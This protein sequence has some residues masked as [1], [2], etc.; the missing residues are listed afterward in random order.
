MVTNIFY[1]QSGAIWKDDFVMFT[2]TLPIPLLGAMELTAWD[3]EG[4]QKAPNIFLLLTDQMVF[5]L[6]I[7]I[8]CALAS[9]FPFL[10]SN[11]LVYSGH[12]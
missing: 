11:I 12:H 1:R 2:R 5:R 8:I 4:C 6:P 9:G 3:M 10:I 7:F